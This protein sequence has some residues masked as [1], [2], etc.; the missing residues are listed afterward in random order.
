MNGS[1]A[2][3]IVGAIISL[4]AIAAATIAVVLGQIDGA[5]FTG[6]IGAAIGGATGGAAHAVVANGRNDTR[7]ET[8]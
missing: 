5:A 7:K 3:V 1:V 6:I 8:P 2:I 4:A